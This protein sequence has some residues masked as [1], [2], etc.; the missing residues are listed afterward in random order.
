MASVVCK[1]VDVI[2]TFRS[3]CRDLTSSVDERFQFSLSSVTA[4]TNLLSSVRFNRGCL[5][6][7]WQITDFES[8]SEYILFAKSYRNAENEIIVF[9]VEGELVPRSPPNRTSSME[10]LESDHLPPI[11]NDVDCEEILSGV[12]AN[13]I[14]KKTPVAAAAAIELPK[15]ISQKSSPDVKIMSDNNKT[16][17]RY[18]S[19]IVSV[20]LAVC[21]SDYRFRFWRGLTGFEKDLNDNLYGQH[22][23]SKVVLKA[24]SSFMTDSN[25]NK[26]LVLSFHGTSGVGKNHVAKIIARNIYE[27]GDQ[28]DHY[29]T[30]I[31][32]HHFPH[33]DKVD[34]V[35]CGFWHSSIIDHHLVDHFI[36]FLPLEL[37]HVRQC[38]LA[39]MASLNIPV[40][41]DLVETVVREMPFF[42]QEEKIFSVKGCKTVKQKL[43]LNIG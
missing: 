8:I 38:V 37:K 16:N 23:V 22:I 28:S 33:K 7:I 9:A 11:L 12:T 1:F 27:K 26:P 18:N 21:S 6:L 20:K 30:V 2:V 4:T 24:V 35:Q 19:F 13:T 29:I 31:S 43:M 34:I 41:H 10:N 17:T 36:P 40:D 25:P 14:A 3:V 15:R 32:E 39:E 42:P 5:V